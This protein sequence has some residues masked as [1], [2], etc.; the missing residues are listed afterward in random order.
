MDTQQIA[1]L[2]AAYSAAGLGDTWAG[3]FLN[4]LAESG[5]LPRGRGVSIAEG[6]LAKGDPETWAHW[7]L[8]MEALE[9]AKRHSNPNSAEIL[10]SIANRVRSGSEISEKQVTLLKGLIES[11]DKPRQM[12]ALERDEMEWLDAVTRKVTSTSSYYW[13]QKPGIRNRIERVFKEARVGYY[14][15]DSEPASEILQES[16][17]FISKQFANHLRDWISAGAAAGELR[18]HKGELCIVIGERSENFGVVQVSVMKSGVH[19][20]VPFGELKAAVRAP[21]RKKTASV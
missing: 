15:H 5:E 10:T 21:R 14:K 6:L 11:S 2:A 20:H 18:T 3:G 7:D 13:A 17:D 16:W 1:S 19:C 9:A 4:S 8:A 12:R